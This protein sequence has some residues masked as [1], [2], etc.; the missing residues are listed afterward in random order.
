MRSRRLFSWM[1]AGSLLGAG[2]SGCATNPV[3]GERELSLI[4]EGQEI[5]MGQQAAQEVSASIGLVANDALQTYVSRIGQRLASASERPQLPWSFAVVDDP[6]PN[7]FALPGGPI[8]V[9][10]GL[11]SLMESEAEL[12]SVLGH[13][14]GHVTARHSVQQLSRA[15][16]AQLGLGIGMILVPEAG[17]LGNLAGAGLQLLFL[18]YGRNAEH[19]ADDL[20]FRYAL[21]QGY[22]VREMADVF[23]SLE[24][25]SQAAGQSPLPSWLSTHPFPQERIERTNERVAALTQPLTNA[26]I[27]RDQ[28][29][30][31]INGM[32]YGANPR[33]G[34]FR[35]SLFLHPELRFR[36]DFPQGWQTQN[37][38]QAVIAASPQQDAILQLTLAQGTPDAAARQF[39]SQQGVS[40][41]APSRESIGGLTASVL[42]FDAQTQQG[43]LRG[44]A[45][46]VAHGSNTY[47]LLGYSPAQRYSA[48][49]AVFQRS[50]GSFANLTDPQVLNIQPN[51]IEI[52][53]LPQAMTLAQFHQR[54]PSAIDIGEL[55]LINGLS[56]AD[57]NIPAGTLVKRVAA[58]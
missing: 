38:A 54:Y 1:L 23:R 52:V 10:R 36:M 42:R 21:S 12:A 44:L 14:I 4:S 17:A 27:G 20:G 51:R 3:T 33:N 49:D 9:T 16:L 5:Q 35:N 57:A 11:M 41:T 39:A 25:A 31:A 30:N 48:Y 58:G 53:R 43:V 13:E 15:Q 26:T 29:L 40:A 19:Q 28:Y 32:V 7:A 22:D 46:F 50:F 18:R 37:M 47:Q 56:G 55:A 6:T 2:A 24:R 34:F 45:V 8:F